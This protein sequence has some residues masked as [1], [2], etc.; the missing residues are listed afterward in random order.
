MGHPNHVLA[1]GGRLNPPGIPSL[2]LALEVDTAIAELQPWRGAKVSLAT[3]RIGQEVE[4]YDLARE[5]QA[6]RG[7]PESTALFIR[8]FF[9]RLFSLPA[10]RDDPAGYAV[11]Q[12]LSEQLKGRDPQVRGIIYPSA[13]H[14]SGEN[15]ALFGTNA[16]RGQMKRTMDPYEV[17]TCLSVEERTVMSV[18][19]QLE[20]VVKAEH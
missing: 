18:D 1:P 19:V 4:V 9:A 20:P 15:L 6:E 17:V 11:T 3:F 10:H 13:M 8:Q 7:T 5:M 2:Y 12:I 14:P 16:W